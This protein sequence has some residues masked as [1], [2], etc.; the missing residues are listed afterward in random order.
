MCAFCGCGWIVE[1]LQIKL[2][3]PINHYTSFIL[4]FNEHNKLYICTQLEIDTY[5]FFFSELFNICASSWFICDQ[6]QTIKMFC[7]QPEA[8]QDEFCES[9]KGDLE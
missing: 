9:E 4:H 5:L 7:E 1:F 6:G 3:S 2:K 8:L